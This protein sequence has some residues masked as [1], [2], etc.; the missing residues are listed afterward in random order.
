MQGT[1]INPRM[2]A[3]QGEYLQKNVK[4]KIW[5]VGQINRLNP[6]RIYPMLILNRR[7]TLNLGHV[8]QDN[9]QFCDTRNRDR[10]AMVFLFCRLYGGGGAVWPP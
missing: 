1:G 6:L 8:G 10:R 5:G 7:Q 9:Q 4:H 2:C 3:A